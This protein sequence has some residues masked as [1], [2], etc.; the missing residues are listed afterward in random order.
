MSLAARASFP[1]PRSFACRRGKRKGAG[2]L[3]GARWPRSQ[4][5]FWLLLAIAAALQEK[6]RRGEAT[7]GVSPFGFDFVNGRKVPRVDEQE[8]LQDIKQL[9][10]DGKSW[11]AVAA[12][13]TQTGR[14]TRTGG[15]F[16]RQGVH[17][18]AR[19]AGLN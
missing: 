14:R 1:R 19:K 2:E 16:S 11:Q 13:L 8:I 17:Q 3:P 7:G 6:R 5:A 12:A 18:I 9:R 4:S 10:A 15:T